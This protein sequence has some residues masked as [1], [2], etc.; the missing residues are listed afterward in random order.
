MGSDIKKPF[1]NLMQGIGLKDT[2]EAMG[3]DL[4]SMQSMLSQDLNSNP[5]YQANQ[6]Q[7]LGNVLSTI[8]SQKSL[9][10]SEQANLA[11]RTN[12]DMQMDALAQGNLANLEQRKLLAD[13]LL[14]RS[15]GQMA[16]KNA[17]SQRMAG[18]MGAGLSAAGAAAA[19]KKPSGGQA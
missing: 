12:R 14:Q 2:L 10:P 5:L 3:G 19:G 16:N 1:N 18:L 11:S 7:A 9:M 8:A 6:K 4:N 13:F 17:S 15:G